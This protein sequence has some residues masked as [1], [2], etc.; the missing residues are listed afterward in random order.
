MDKRGI[1]ILI[2]CII[3]TIIVSILFLF[4]FRISRL[5]CELVSIDPQ[6]MRTI[7][8]ESFD[9]KSNKP[10]RS[11]DKTILMKIS[12]LLEYNKMSNKMNDQKI[13][14]SSGLQQQQATLTTEGTG[15]L[16]SSSSQFSVSGITSGTQTNAIHPS[17]SQPQ[18]AFNINSNTNPIQTPQQ[19]GKNLTIE[20]QSSRAEK[21]FLPLELDSI[22]TRN[23]ANN[24]NQQHGIDSNQLLSRHKYILSFNCT[25][26]NM[27]FVYQESR[28]YVES[29]SL[30]LK[31]SSHEKSHC[32]LE[33]PK[34]GIAVEL[35]RTPA[36]NLVALHSNDI[37]T[38]GNINA[39]INTTNINASVNANTNV[40]S[41]ISNNQ[42]NANNSSSNNEH[43]AHYYCNRPLS[44]SCRHFSRSGPSPSNG[45]LLAE[46]HV[47]SI[48]FETAFLR[49][50]RSERKRVKHEFA[51]KRSKIASC[52]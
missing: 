45:L 12:V 32:E 16:S 8:L 29:M 27:V 25:K 34:S 37:N 5:N 2:S 4:A 49:P 39:N 48:E 28:V 30:E 14:N 7:H 44:L 19:S 9:K 20:Q 23:L 17:P 15:N 6:R 18:L 35:D 26:L 41:T 38:S 52:V 22:E 13:D 33:L 36:N 11:H 50:N 1:K 31:P 3:C 10:I 21:R 42:N 47:N 51:S 43:L 40:N 24:E 46:L